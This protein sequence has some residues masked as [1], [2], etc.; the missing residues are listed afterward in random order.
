MLQLLNGIEGN[1]SLIDDVLVHGRMQEE[2]DERLRT[3]LLRPQEAGLTLKKEKC[4]FSSNWVK[5]LAKSSL[6]QVS[7]Q[8]QTK[9]HLSWSYQSQSMY[10]KFDV[11][12]GW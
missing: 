6:K 9:L 4:I 8:I 5:F 12:G 1:I 11:L 3:V 7:L 10:M 2:H